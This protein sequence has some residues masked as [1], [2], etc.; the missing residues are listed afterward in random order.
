MHMKK[1]SDRR[2]FLCDDCGM[3]FKFKRALQEHVNVIHK[4]IRNFP[5]HLCDHK[6]ATK[7]GVGVKI[8]DLGN[9]GEEDDDKEEVMVVMVAMIATLL[10]IWH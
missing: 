7:N 8:E 4:D 2:E 1:H 6:A 3:G 5:C 9:V 10:K